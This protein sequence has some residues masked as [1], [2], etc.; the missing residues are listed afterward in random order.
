MFWLQT[1][2]LNRS[3]L[4][5][6]YPS[7]PKGD[8]L[9]RELMGCLM[10][11][12]NQKTIAIAVRSVARYANTPRELLWRIAIGILEY[13]FSTRLVPLTLLSKGAL[14]LSW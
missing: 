11:L 9:L 2:P 10:W 6:V 12:A 7:K 14:Y 4:E 1:P 3:E 5:K 13:A 8:W